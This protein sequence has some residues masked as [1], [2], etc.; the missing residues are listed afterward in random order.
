[1]AKLVDASALG[2]DTFG[3]GSSSL[4]SSTFFM[5][6]IDLHDTKTCADALERLEHALFLFQQSGEYSCRVV[7]GIGEGVLANAVHNALTKNP[8]IHQ[9]EEE[10]GGGSCVVLF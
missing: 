4:P 8:L 5:K 1:M 3:R 9:W 7:H 2:A 6:T 10:E